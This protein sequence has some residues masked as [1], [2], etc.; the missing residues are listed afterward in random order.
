MFDWLTQLV[1]G[2]PISYVVVGIAAGGDVLFPPSP[3]VTIVIT[4]SV[5]AAQGDLIIWLIVPLVALG[6]MIGD[7]ISFLL[8]A[9]VGDPIA[10]RLFRS[11]K[12]RRRL[13]WA[14]GAIQRHGALLVVVGRF[15]PGGRTASTFAAGTLEMPWRRFIVADAVAAVAWAVYACMLGYLGGSTFR[16]SLWKPLLLSLGAA[17]LISL[18]VE[19][20]R[21]F[22]QHRGKDLFGEKTPDSEQT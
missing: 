5:L 19:G 22:Q 6:A 1:S 21:R 13:Q 2:N 9:R 16:T 15:I 7:N 10:N 12:N 20:W 8:G 4:A 3:S 11:D 18:F 17:T 14:E